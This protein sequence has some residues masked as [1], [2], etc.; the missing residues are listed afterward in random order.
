MS[1][2]FMSFIGHCLVFYFLP[3]SIT[4]FIKSYIISTVHACASVLVVCIFFARS[5]INLT[6]VNRILGGGINGTNDEMMTYSICYSSGYF[7]YDILVM[8]YFK[9][10]RTQ[11]A[12]IHHMIILT[13]EF[14][15]NNTFS[16]RLFIMN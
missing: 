1:L 10:V 12:L 15:G 14:S 6:Q 9:S 11:S 16:S 13:A 5:S 2:I 3:S 7:I 4:P 8:L